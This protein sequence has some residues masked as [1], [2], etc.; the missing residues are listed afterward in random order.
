MKYFGQGLLYLIPLGVT[1]MVF[2]WIYNLIDRFASFG[3]DMVKTQTGVEV[4]H[5][6][7]VL[8]ASIL[9]FITIVGVVGPYLFSTPI[10]RYFKNLINR[11]PVI[12]MIYSSVQDLLSVF[13][14]NKKKFTQPVIFK[15]SES[16]ELEMIGF[17]TQDDLTDLNIEDKKV[18]V[19]VPFSFSIMGALYVIP[20][21]NVKMLNTP[22]QDILKFV[23]SGGISK[24]EDSDTK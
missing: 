23:I 13:V 17:L 20:A 11:T 8:L 22:P 16:S 1:V 18:S 14:G 9:I 4:K 5:Y 3:V 7:W 19:Y 15:V 2:I 10:S 6:Y 24:T 21:K 12:K